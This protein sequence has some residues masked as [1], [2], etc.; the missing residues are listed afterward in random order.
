[1]NARIGSIPSP[2][3]RSAEG[4]GV[5]CFCPAGVITNITDAYLEGV[6]RDYT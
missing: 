1:M 6:I 3:D 5:S 2:I 4:I